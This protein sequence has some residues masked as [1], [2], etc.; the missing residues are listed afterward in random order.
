MKV[1]VQQVVTKLF[2]GAADVLT[3]RLKEARDFV[4]GT[5]AVTYCLKH[6]GPELQ[7]L[8]IFNE[9]SVTMIVKPARM[10][11][12]RAARA[13][14]LL[15]LGT[16]HSAGR[17]RPSLRRNGLQATEAATSNKSKMSLKSSGQAADVFDSLSGVAQH[18]GG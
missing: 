15:P 8:L 7:I 1:V 14:K 3:R 13:H 18:S 17:E 12:M 16:E 4:I 5:K 6:G 9:P 2:I 11:R 10:V